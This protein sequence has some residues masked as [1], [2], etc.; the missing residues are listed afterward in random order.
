MI[1]E[2]QYNFYREM[3]QKGLDTELVEWLDFTSLSD[4]GHGWIRHPYLCTPINTDAPE[5]HINH[6]NSG[7]S[8]TKKRIDKLIDDGDWSKLLLFVAKPYKFYKF[9]EIQTKLTDKEYW[10]TLRETFITTHHQTHQIDDWISCFKS[11]RQEKES[12]MDE[13]DLDF[14]NQLP[15]RIKIWRGANSEDFV[16]GLSWSTDKERG[17]WFARRFGHIY[18]EFLLCESTIEKEGILMCSKH[19]NLIV[20][21]PD[22]LPQILV[23]ELE[24]EDKSIT[25]NGKIR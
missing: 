4:D 8:D 9:L 11:E 6:I 1:E 12:L 13:D 23:T 10:E 5:G 14:Y 17:K 15:D 22:D 25:R 18:G 20:C 3:L 21:N 2:E 7:F 24:D 16:K 19:E